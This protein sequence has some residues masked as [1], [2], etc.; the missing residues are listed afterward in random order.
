GRTLSCLHPEATILFVTSY[1]PLLL[2]VRGSSP[3][4]CCR[5]PRWRRVSRWRRLGS[6]LLWRLQTTRWPTAWNGTRSHLPALLLLLLLSLLHHAGDLGGVTLK[7]IEPGAEPHD[8]RYRP[9]I[10]KPLLPV[11]VGQ[12]AHAEVLGNDGSGLEVVGG[13]V[14]GDVELIDVEHIA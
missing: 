12:L 13:G 7:L 11:D 1:G 10:G 9:A 5:R 8:V 2:R 4:P 3:L 6:S 14:L